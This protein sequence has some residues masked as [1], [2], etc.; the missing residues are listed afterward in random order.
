MTYYVL[1]PPEN[2]G[3]LPT[4][5]PNWDPDLHCPKYR[6]ISAEM[7]KEA[8]KEEKRSYKEFV[9]DEP[10][11]EPQKKALGMIPTLDLIPPNGF[12]FDSDKDAEAFITAVARVSDVSVDIVNRKIT[13]RR[14][15]QFLNKVSMLRG[16]REETKKGAPDVSLQE[17][18]DRHWRAVIKE[19][20]LARDFTPELVSHVTL[21]K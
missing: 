1:E 6:V 21:S 13:G 15:Y 2:C 9:D 14:L 7:Q 11:Y 17:R 19:A 16:E 8:K 3:D 5:H 4:G 12:W 18:R 10:I 20:P